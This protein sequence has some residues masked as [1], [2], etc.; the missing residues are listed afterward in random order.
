MLGDASLPGFEDTKESWL[1]CGEPQ[2]PMMKGQIKL[3]L[4]YQ[5]QAFCYSDRKWARTQ[6]KTNP[7]LVKSLP[8]FPLPVKRVRT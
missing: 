6:S 4:S 7:L 1:S 5:P 8:F 2:V 3:F